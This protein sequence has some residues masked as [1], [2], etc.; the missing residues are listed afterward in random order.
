MRIGINALNQ[1]KQVGTINDSSLTIV[2]LDENDPNYPFKGW[3]TNKISCY[4]YKNDNGI[5]S[6]YPYID[7]NIMEKLLNL[8]SNNDNPGGGNGGVFD[9]GLI[10]QPADIKQ[11]FGGLI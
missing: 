11:D 6:I 8:P 2:E 9:Y 1:I 10:T 4:H 5:I 3:S 7:T